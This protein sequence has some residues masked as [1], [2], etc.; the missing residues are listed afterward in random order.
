MAFNIK[1]KTKRSS[2]VYVPDETDHSEG[3]CFWRSHTHHMYSASTV[4]QLWHIPP[5]GPPTGTQKIH[6]L[7]AL[8]KWI[9]GTVHPNYVILSFTLKL[10]QSI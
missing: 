5:L 8:P 3:R 10:F 4:V 9:K 6:D 1:K 7:T 2:Y